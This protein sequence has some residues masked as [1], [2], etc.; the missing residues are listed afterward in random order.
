VT[1]WSSHQVR[2]PLLGIDGVELL[3]V[4]FLRDPIAR[5]WSA[6]RFE[7]NQGGVSPSSR[8]AQSSSF[9]DWIEFHRGRGSHQVA[10]FQV[11]S[12]S[13]LR[14]HETGRP[15]PGVSAAEHAESAMAWLET[16]PVVGLVERFEESVEQMA[17]W[18][19]PPLGGFETATVHANAGEGGSDLDRI[20]DELGADAFDRLLAENRSDI[21]LWSR[22]S[23]R[24][25]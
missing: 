10:N 2:P 18:L 22:T 17:A 20:R 21:A 23:R 12:L 11:M 8:A 1:A 19:G 7:R 4:V 16:V 6:Y 13:L 15:T 14:D 25:L 5:I 24:N 3:P 9:A